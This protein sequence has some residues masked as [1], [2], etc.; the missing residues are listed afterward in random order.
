AATWDVS[1][2]MHIAPE[3]TALAGSRIDLSKFEKTLWILVLRC[4][5]RKLVQA[6]GLEI[7]IYEEDALPQFG[8]GV[9]DVGERESPSNPALV[10]V[11][12]DEKGH[13]CYLTGKL[14]RF[15]EGSPVPEP[16]LARAFDAGRG[17]LHLAL[18]TCR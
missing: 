12:S 18:I 10:R 4:K 11:E 8:Q 7:H 5:F 17:L 13:G 9:G 15:G 16:D 3:I 6:R 14:D 1:T 2:R